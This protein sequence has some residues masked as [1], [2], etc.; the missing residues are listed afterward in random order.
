LARQRP[1]QIFDWIDY[2]HTN[3][4]LTDEWNK[5]EPEKKKALKDAGF[6]EV[7]AEKAANGY[8]KLPYKPISRINNMAKIR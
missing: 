7:D 3:Q 8:A 5:A 2:E 4:D 1:S 6:S